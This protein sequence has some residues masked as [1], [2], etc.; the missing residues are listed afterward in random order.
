MVIENPGMANALA[1]A[2]SETF[3]QASHVPKLTSDGAMIWD[4][5]A[6]NGTQ[7]RHREDPGTNPFSQLLLW[8]LSLLPTEWLL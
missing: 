1:A 4:E 3:Q 7:I 6:T 8:L 2:F 5:V